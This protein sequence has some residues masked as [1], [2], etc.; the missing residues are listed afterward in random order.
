MSYQE[1]A[2]IEEFKTSIDVRSMSDPLNH[3][4]SSHTNSKEV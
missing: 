2:T 3:Y 4:E 1:K